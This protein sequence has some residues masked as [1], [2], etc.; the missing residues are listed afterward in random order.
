MTDFYFGGSF[1]IPTE[2]CSR[3]DRPHCR[4]DKEALQSALS[5]K[6]DYRVVRANHISEAINNNI[7]SP[8][9]SLTHD[10]FRSTIKLKGASPNGDSDEITVRTK[11]IVDC[12][13]HETK[14]VLK[15][16]KIKS[17]FQM[18]F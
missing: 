3:I 1:G 9:G 16:A 7:Y 13:G 10:A 17:K 4:I 8:S 5:K 2:Q 11:L 14:L 15:D 18:Y 6:G 12:T